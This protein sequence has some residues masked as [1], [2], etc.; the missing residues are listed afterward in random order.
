[1]RARHPLPRCVPANTLYESVKFDSFVKAN[2]QL[3]GAM[4]MSGRA[5]SLLIL[6]TLNSAGEMT[7]RFAD[8]SDVIMPTS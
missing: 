2:Q 7:S 4:A 3:I 8:A 5:H 1:M 6:D